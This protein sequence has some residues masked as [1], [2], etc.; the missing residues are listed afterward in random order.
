MRWRKEGTR[1]RRCTKE[2]E[3]KYWDSEGREGNGRSNWRGNRREGMEAVGKVRI[4][5]GTTRYSGVG[6]S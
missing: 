2:N 3:E 4:G 6:I 1:G 5:V